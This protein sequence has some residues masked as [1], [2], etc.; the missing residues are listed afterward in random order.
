MTSLFD[1]TAI[2]SMSLRNRL[3]RSATWEG[4]CEP[5]GQPTRK[6]AACY[7]ALAKGGVG[8]IISGYTF[9]RVEGK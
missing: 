4:M 3:V 9:V 5:S 7:A 2:K 6:L 8:L 1:T